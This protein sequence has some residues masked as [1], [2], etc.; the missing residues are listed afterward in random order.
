M[1]ALLPVAARP[2]SASVRLIEPG[3]RVGPVDRD[4][5]LD[6]LRKSLGSRNVA[7]GRVLDEDGSRVPGVVLYPGDPRRRIEI[8]WADTAA[9]RTP[10]WARMRGRSNAWRTAAGVRVG[11]SLLELEK[12]NGRA[13]TIW[14]FGGAR[15]GRVRSWNDGALE[16]EMS[17][18]R[19]SFG[20][21]KR[22]TAR[23]IAA[24]SQGAVLPSGD[25][26]LRRLNPKVSEILIR[27][28]SED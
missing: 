16:A 3:V 6:A 10:A 15:P 11:T 25:P 7:A 22:A 8:A 26:T 21:P 5:S 14:G 19:V 18:A 12:L 24:V 20:L 28:A 4:A 1:L 23:E 27:F 13:L 17:P 9:R 2:D